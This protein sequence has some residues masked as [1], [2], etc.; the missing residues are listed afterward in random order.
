MKKASNELEE[1]LLTLKDVYDEKLVL[2]EKIAR[3]S[4][5]SKK[6]LCHN[7]FMTSLN[8]VVI[9]FRTLII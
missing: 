5:F 6:H 7:T 3:I 2:Y 1:I 8:Q 4:E 9:C